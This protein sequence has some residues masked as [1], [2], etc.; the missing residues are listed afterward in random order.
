VVR[1]GRGFLGF[2]SVLLI[3]RG[4]VIRGGVEKLALGD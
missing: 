3:H 2:G 1:A 4:R